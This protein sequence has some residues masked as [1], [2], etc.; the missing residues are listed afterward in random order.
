MPMYFLGTMS[1]FREAN[2]CILS[3]K[4]HLPGARFHLFHVLSNRHQFLHLLDRDLFHVISAKMS[5]I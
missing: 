4:K 2:P 1:S 3:T 5:M